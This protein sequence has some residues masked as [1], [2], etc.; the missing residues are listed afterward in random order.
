MIVEGAIIAILVVFVVLGL[1]LTWK[2][3]FIVAGITTIIYYFIFGSVAVDKYEEAVKV[4]EEAP[5]KQA[6]F[7][8][9]IS[10][11][12]EK[13]ANWTEHKEHF[14]AVGLTEGWEMHKEFLEATMVE[15]TEQL[16]TAEEEE[17]KAS[18]QAKE[19]ENSIFSVLVEEVQ[20]D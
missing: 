17:A 1:R 10:S 14:E 4:I 20:Y 2:I 7:K 18:E 11:V 13:L 6:L 19:I 8:G 3:A 16:Q 15:A 12:E 9:T 5:A